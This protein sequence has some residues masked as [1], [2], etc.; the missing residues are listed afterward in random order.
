MTKALRTSLLLVS[1]LTLAACSPVATLRNVVDSPINW[2]F[3]QSVGGIAV[4]KPRLEG[5]IFWLPLDVDLSGN[6]AISANPTVTNSGRKCI[7]AELRQA[8]NIASTPGYYDLYLQ[9]W[10][11]D[12]DQ[13]QQGG[14]DEVALFIA[15]LTPPFTSPDRWKF[16]IWY[17]DYILSEHFIA[18][19]AL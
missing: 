2:D 19:V 10:S 9:I 15:S 17:K 8:D 18:E 1:A 4:G 16:R 7:R 13:R 6:R 3:L 12:L 5:N 14:C 11:G